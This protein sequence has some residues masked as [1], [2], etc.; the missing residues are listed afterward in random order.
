MKKTFAHSHRPEAASLM[1]RRWDMEMGCRAIVSRPSSSI[2]R[3]DFLQFVKTCD[4]S[5]QT[6]S[7]AGAP[8]SL[9]ARRAKLIRGACLRIF[10]LPTSQRAGVLARRAWR[11]CGR[12]ANKGLLAMRASKQTWRNYLGSSLAC[13]PPS[14][15]A[16]R[17]RNS[18][19]RT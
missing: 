1:K 11:I 4:D 7:Q 16:F 3:W 18:N 15:G 14:Y 9:F 12:V 10:H 17:M 8:N 5:R 2:K 19:P 13:F 6:P